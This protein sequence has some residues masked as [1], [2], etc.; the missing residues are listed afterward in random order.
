MMYITGGENHGD[1]FEAASHRSCL[2]ILDYLI[3]LKEL[4][5]TSAVLSQR[6]YEIW[7]IDYIP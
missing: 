7:L 6:L 1:H 3:N 5:D 4:Y 2:V